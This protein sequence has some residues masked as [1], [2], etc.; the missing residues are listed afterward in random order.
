MTQ[1]NAARGENLGVSTRTQ[2]WMLSAG[3]PQCWHRDS[4]G[5]SLH[6]CNGEEGEAVTLPG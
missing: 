6:G 5:A 4:Q 2:L 1:V 3:H